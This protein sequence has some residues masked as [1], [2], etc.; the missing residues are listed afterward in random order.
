MR[1]PLVILAATLTLPLGGCLTGAGRAA[2][3]VLP[4]LEVGVKREKTCADYARAVNDADGDSELTTRQ[5]LSLMEACE[6]DRA[7]GR[8]TIDP[9]KGRAALPSIGTP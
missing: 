2:I 3:P 6:A 8:L 9:D 7:A 5:V 4:Q 1:T